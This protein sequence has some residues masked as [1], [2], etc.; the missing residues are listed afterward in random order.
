MPL[1]FD[2]HLLPGA[3]PEDIGNASTEQV[4]IQADYGAETLKWY[5]DGK[6]GKAF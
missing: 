5:C 3:T 1:Y 4:K 2:M 6:T